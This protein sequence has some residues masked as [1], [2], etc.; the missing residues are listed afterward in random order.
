MWP[1]Y[2]MR[3]LSGEQ[4]MLANVTGR[5]ED[6]QLVSNSLVPQDIWNG[7]DNRTVFRSLPFPHTQQKHTCTQ[8]IWCLERVF[9]DEGLGIPLNLSDSQCL[10]TSDAFKPACAVLPPFPGSITLSFFPGNEPGARSMPVRFNWDRF[11]LLPPLPLQPVGMNHTLTKS[12]RGDGSMRP[13]GAPW[14]PNRELSAQK[15]PL[16]QQVKGRGKTSYRLLSTMFPSF[17]SLCTMFFYNGKNSIQLQY[18][19]EDVSYTLVSMQTDNHHSSIL[20]KNQRK[21]ACVIILLLQYDK[22][23][24]KQTDI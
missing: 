11:P 7:R 2:N 13:D 22:L 19:P 15:T 4:H 5:T 21:M 6:F 1:S 16:A 18:I 23:P 12:S 8:H 9:M 3:E 24:K 20:Q 10:P 14:N 17:K